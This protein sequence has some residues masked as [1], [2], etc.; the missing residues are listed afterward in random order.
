VQQ[1]DAFQF[2]SFELELQLE[3]PSENTCAANPASLLASPSSQ[4]PLLRPGPLRTGRETFVLIRLKPFERLFQGDAVSVPSRVPRQGSPPTSLRKRAGWLFAGAR[5]SAFRLTL[6]IESYAR[7]TQKKQTLTTTTASRALK[8]RTEDLQSTSRT[9]SGRNE[10][11]QS[12]ADNPPQGR[13][14][15]ITQVI[16]SSRFAA[17]VRASGEKALTLAQKERAIAGMR[18]A[19]ATISSSGTK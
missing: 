6:C 18:L 1:K 8:L 12:S 10:G 4:A 3:L 5:Y 19:H 14:L 16:T 9:R 11:G 15:C 13:I 7:P 2:L 17:C